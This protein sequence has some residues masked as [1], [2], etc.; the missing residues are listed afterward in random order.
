MKQIYTTPTK[1][2]KISV[3]VYN[4]FKDILPHGTSFYSEVEDGIII[5]GLESSLSILTSHLD[6]NN[7]Q[8]EWI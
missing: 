4:I 2:I 3:D 6:R 7:T 8:W 1:K 5:E